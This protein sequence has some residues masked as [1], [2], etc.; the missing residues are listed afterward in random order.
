MFAAPRFIAIDDNE[1]HLNAITQTLQMIGTP[2]YAILYA[3]DYE[4]EAE[5]FQGARC[6]MVD[7][8]LTSGILSTDENKHYALIANILEQNISPNGGPFILIVWTEYPQ[9]CDG[10][11]DYL[12]SH[13]DTSKPHARPLA[14]L[15][16]PKANFI[17]TGDGTVNDPV[18]LKDAVK[19]LVASNPQLAVLLEWETDVLAAAGHTLAS[20]LNL[21]A[22][23]KRATGSYS[24]ELDTILSRLANAAVGQAHVAGDPRSAV[25][26]S[27]VPILA[28]RIVSQ[29]GSGESMKLWKEAV[30]KSDTDDAGNFAS[31]AG[32][33]NRMLHLAISGT[34][35]IAASDWG[36]VVTFPFEWSDSELTKRFGVSLADILSDELKLKDEDRS[37]SKGVLVRIGAACDY[38]QAKKGP[39]TYLLGISTAA[40]PTKTLPASI[41]KSPPF[42]EPQAADSFYLYVNCRMQITVPP[43]D[44]KD[45]SVLY[46]IREQLLMQL[47]TT[48]SNHAS[49]PGIVSL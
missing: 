22:D 35:T 31:G 49:R 36:A 37:K 2:C 45:W 20:L 42:S 19:K 6:I 30:T 38:A 14:V 5:H 12:N 48:A 41:W 44:C 10:L 4:F 25:V 15:P 7:L 26:K 32:E 46:R 8:H 27:L 16:L 9:R 11:R 13:L 1:A 47:I 43:D 17:N 29:K 3:P 33:I 34:E 24:A 40:K 18:K 28:D 39:I 23:D 21:V